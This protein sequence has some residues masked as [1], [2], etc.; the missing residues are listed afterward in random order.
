MKTPIRVLTTLLF[1]AALLGCPHYVA[2][3][4]HP[5]PAQYIV[6]AGFDTTWAVVEGYVAQVEAPIEVSDRKAGILATKPMPA[7]PAWLDCG[8]SHHQECRRDARGIGRTMRVN[9]WVTALGADSSGIT[10]SGKER[11][12][13]T[14]KAAEA[15]GKTSSCARRRANSRRRWHG[16]SGSWLTARGKGRRT[17]KRARRDSGTGGQD[18]GTG[19]REPVRHEHFGV[20]IDQTPSISPTI[21]FL[22]TRPV[23]G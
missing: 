15:W 8:T 4:M 6:H 3:V 18:P 21:S 13:Q 9:V 11:V 23:P 16:W 7:D 20:P 19:N 10:V 5:V 14:V 12:E 17:E 22:T 2:P 1:V